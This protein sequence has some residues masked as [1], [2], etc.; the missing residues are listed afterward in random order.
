M[1]E[2]GR[3]KPKSPAFI[4][5]LF[6]VDYDEKTQKKVV[7]HVPEKVW[8]SLPPLL[9]S[10]VSN[11]TIAQLLPLLRSEVVIAEV[12]NSKGREDCYLADLTA[13]AVNVD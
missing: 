13:V 2:A 4:E 6:I 9:E 3:N 11:P 5:D 10:D 7:Y 12:T 8:K 1:S